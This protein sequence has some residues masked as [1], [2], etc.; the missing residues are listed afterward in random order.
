VSVDAS[1]ADA[2]RLVYEL[3][4]PTDV[5]V[6]AH[7]ILL[8]KLN[9]EWRT[10]RGTSGTLGAEPLRLSADDVG[11]W[12]GHNGWRVSVPPGASVIWPAL[13]HNPYVKDGSA[14]PAEGRIVLVLPF[15]SDVMRH[16]VTIAVP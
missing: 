14:K 12:F 11:K 13:P 15:T 7:V 10:S 6:E 1:S 3:E 8:A 9:N 5:P 16:E 2:A 4:S